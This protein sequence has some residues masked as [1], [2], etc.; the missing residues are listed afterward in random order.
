MQS[1]LSVLMPRK[2]GAG[3][4]GGRNFTGGRPP[5]AP[6]RTAPARRGG[7]EEWGPTLNR[8]R[9]LLLPRD[10]VYKPGMPS[11][12]VCPSVCLSVRHVRVS[13]RNE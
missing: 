3:A 2:W 8:L 12:G 5:L 4:Q 7:K 11:C 9:S 13:C 1:K 6:H 10:I